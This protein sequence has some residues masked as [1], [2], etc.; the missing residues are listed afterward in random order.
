MVHKRDVLSYLVAAKSFAQHA[1]PRR[2]V[3]VCDPSVDQGDRKIFKHHIPHVE[4]RNAAEFVDS[5]LP[6]GGCW[7]RLLAISQYAK[8]DYVVQLDADT[9]TI[10]PI[11]EINAAIQSQSGFV[12]G[13]A[14]N[15]RPMSVIETSKL[16]KNLPYEAR[17]I[18]DIAESKM[19]EACGDPDAMY[20]RGCAGFTGFPPSTAMNDKIVAYSLA[21]QRLIA[22]RW[23][24][25]GTEQVTSNYIVAN[26]N[27]TKILPFPKYCTPDVG[28]NDTAFLHFI[29]YCRFVNMKYE[30]TSKRVIQS[31]KSVPV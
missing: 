25:W 19:A 26:A 9:V 24:T 5:Q 7:E 1:N 31:L 27:G 13:E 17:H 8:T 11:P 12:L 16:A 15:Q 23:S 2:I 3:V 18:Q 30:L 10:R 28:T 29:G 22:E 6:T 14:P 21:M 20:I 4:L